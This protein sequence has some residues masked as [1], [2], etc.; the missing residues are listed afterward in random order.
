MGIGE[1]AAVTPTRRMQKVSQSVIDESTKTWGGGGIHNRVT[2]K[3]RKLSNFTP[4]QG[5]KET[6][7]I[8]AVSVRMPTIVRQGMAF[9]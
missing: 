4:L 7:L 6:S 3:G 5:T 9:P 1:S 8:G 2:A